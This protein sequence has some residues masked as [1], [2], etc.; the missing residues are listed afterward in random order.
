MTQVK[1]EREKNLRDEAADI[2]ISFDHLRLG[3]TFV[4]CVRLACPVR[5]KKAPVFTQKVSLLQLLLSVV[6]PYTSLSL[7]MTITIKALF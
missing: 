3:H 6:S 2:Q 4:C 5:E 1:L 7:T